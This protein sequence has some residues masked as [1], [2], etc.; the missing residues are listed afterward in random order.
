MIL[1]Q[2]GSFILNETHYDIQPPAKMTSEQEYQDGVP[3]RIQ[4]VEMPEGNGEK[5][6][7][8]CG[9]KTCQLFHNLQ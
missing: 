3:H 6:V 7:W 2:E 4:K 8:Y 1:L 5:M 9:K